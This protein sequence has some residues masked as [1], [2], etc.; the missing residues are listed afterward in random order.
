M[1]CDN[2]VC[3]AM[4]WEHC[5]RKLKPDIRFRTSN[6]LDFITF[7]LES[8]NIDYASINTEN[9]G[10]KFMSLRQNVGQ[11]GNK[12]AANKSLQNVTTFTYFGTPA[13]NQNYIYD[14]TKINLNS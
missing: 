10:C 2:K 4:R 11:N 14:E 7:I 9:T 6:P 12:R 3:G 1:K 13:T 5:G 8:K